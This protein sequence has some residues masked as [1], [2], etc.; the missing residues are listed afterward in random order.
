MI[1]FQSSV[2]DY[3]SDKHPSKLYRHQLNN[4]AYA[5]GFDDT[6]K[7]VTVAKGLASERDSSELVR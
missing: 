6:M 2:A 1:D 5:G 3:M 7:K 4:V